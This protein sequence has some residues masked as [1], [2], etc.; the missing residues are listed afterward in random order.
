MALWLCVRK[1]KNFLFRLIRVMRLKHC[2]I[3]IP[4]EIFHI[5]EYC[6]IVYVKYQWSIH[7]IF[8]LPVVLNKFQQ[9]TRNKTPF[10]LEQP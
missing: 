7:N 4:I 6:A 5:N 8:Y 1:Q 3:S 10:N 2:I 9:R